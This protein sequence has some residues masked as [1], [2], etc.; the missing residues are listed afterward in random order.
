MFELDHKFILEQLEIMYFSRPKSYPR[1][2][3]HYKD[4]LT[5]ASMLKLDSIHRNRNR[6]PS[7]G[8]LSSFTRFR[9]VYFIALD[10][11]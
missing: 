5:I 4:M 6:H 11:Y 1:R 9:I 2:H 10:C 7:I 8:N 3:F